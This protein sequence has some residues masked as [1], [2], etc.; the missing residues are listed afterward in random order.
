ML[1]VIAS[2]NAKEYF[3][4]SLKREDYYSEGQEVR[5]D[6]NGMAAVRLGLSGAVTQADFDS[7][8]D[9]T[10]QKQSDGGL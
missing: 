1:R 9:A 4:E 2:R 10:E 6:W 8:C 5:G 7:L 3:A